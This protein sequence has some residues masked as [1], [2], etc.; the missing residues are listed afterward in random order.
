MWIL[1][2]H[3]RS[4][5]QQT[6]LYGSRESTPWQRNKWM[7]F[8][9]GIQGSGVRTLRGLWVDFVI[10]NPVGFQ[11]PI[12]SDRRR[13]TL[14]RR[15]LVADQLHDYFSYSRSGSARSNFGLNKWA[16]Q[17]KRST[18]LNTEVSIPTL[19]LSYP[20]THLQT[21][22]VIRYSWTGCIRTRR[23]SDTKITHARSI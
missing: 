15:N 4:G 7:P 2:L 10:W 8:L 19:W 3:W 21:P 1:G 16:R 17:I 5:R 13:R 11:Y 6:T 20:E 23:E 14:L 18:F 9:R 22:T 12:W